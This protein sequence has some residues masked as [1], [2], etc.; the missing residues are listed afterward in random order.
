MSKHRKTW[1]KSEKLEILAMAERETVLI[2]S[3]H[4]GVSTTSIYKW[5]DLQSSMGDDGLEKL[6]ETSLRR[7]NKIL[8]DENKELK[9]MN[10]EKELKI[11]LLEQ[12]LKKKLALWKKGK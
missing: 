6:N 4:Y 2:A 7:E 11:R 1:S 5:M 3:R 9:E 12:Q 8:V 10:I